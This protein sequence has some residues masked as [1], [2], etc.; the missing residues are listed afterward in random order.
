M[1]QKFIDKDGLKVLWNQISLKD[2]PN[3]ETL[4]AVIDAIDETKADKDEIIQADWNQTDENKLDF[5]KNK[6][7]GEEYSN[8]YYLEE[9]TVNIEEHSDLHQAWIDIPLND[10]VY[11]D[12]KYTVVFD[13]I[14]Y[15]AT[16]YDEEGGAFIGINYYYPSDNRDNLPFGLWF[17]QFASKDN[18]LYGLSQLAAICATDDSL[19]GE[20]TISIYAEGLKINKIDEKYLP[21]S[22]LDIPELKDEITSL[23]ETVEVLPS[24]MDKENPTGSGA[25]SLNRNL[26]SLSGNFS[27]SMGYN[28]IA[29][30]K[31]Q[32]AIG[33]YNIG[34]GGY[35]VVITKYD[36]ST[37]IQLN[38]NGVYAS[39]KY[40]FDKNTGLFTIESPSYFN[41]TKIT[42]SNLRGKYFMNTRRGSKMYFFINYSN[43]T[44]NT[45]TYELKIDSYTEYKSSEP[46]NNIRGEYVHI[47]GNGQSD[48][49]RSNAHTVDWDGNANYA[50]DVYVGNANEN[51]AGKK[52]A[53]EEY[54]DSQIPTDD[55][56]LALSVEM[57]LIEPIENNGYV[58]TDANGVIYTI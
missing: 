29:S 31:S 30:R 45:T 47:I 18:E 57:G 6:P 50:G 19:I 52:L 22:V 33:E 25:F 4:M 32:T 1:T 49:E 21:N 43:S 46:L 5:I 7:F 13:G 15:E 10:L 23:K 58:L 37:P 36:S 8:I 41:T 54:V 56:A 24:K 11:R 27:Q 35:E 2:Y 9:Q 53:T 51:K 17:S 28:N 20:H 14:E 44:Y 34:E 42:S 40:T 38:G 12:N 48:E 55:D 26:N 39:G 16:L 3:N